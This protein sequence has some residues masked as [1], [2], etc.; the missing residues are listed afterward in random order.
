MGALAAAGGTAPHIGKRQPAGGQLWANRPSEAVG[1]PLVRLRGR[2]MGGIGLPP[3]RTRRQ[4]AM[5]ARHQKKPPGREPGARGAE[6]IIAPLAGAQGGVLRCRPRLARFSLSDQQLTDVLIR[7]RALGRR[8]TDSAF[9]RRQS[10]NV[11]A[12]RGAAAVGEDGGLS[13]SPPRWGRRQHIRQY[14]RY[15]CHPRQG[16]LQGDRQEQGRATEKPTS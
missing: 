5:T 12:R 4:C 9:L 14:S 6:C 1:T 15:R 8:P 2:G 11:L 10:S 16:A 13:R 7:G 3:G